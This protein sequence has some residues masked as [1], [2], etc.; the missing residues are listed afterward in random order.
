MRDFGIGLALETIEGY[1]RKS[2]QRT[3]KKDKRDS[4]LFLL[5]RAFAANQIL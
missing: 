4:V 2:A 3:Q 1:W 5:L